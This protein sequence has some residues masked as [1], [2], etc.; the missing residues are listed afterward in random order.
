MG[1]ERDEPATFAE[2]L[3]DAEG[4][5]ASPSSLRRGPSIL[6]DESE[7]ALVKQLPDLLGRIQRLGL[8][9]EYSAFKHSYAAWRRGKS[10]GA[11]GEVTHDHIT[12]PENL[13]GN[14]RLSFKNPTLQ[15][16]VW[17]RTISYWICVTFFEGSLFFA[18]SCFLS[19]WEDE[20]G[21]VFVPLTTFGCVAGKACFFVGCYFMCLEVINM[22]V[23]DDDDSN[24]FYFWPYRYRVAL[25]KLASVGSDA[26][27]FI[28]G[29]TYLT[30]VLFYVVGMS[31]DF[32]PLSPDVAGPIHLWT[33]MVGAI[34]F[35]IG[36]FAE[37]IQNR[38][39]TRE[40]TQSSIAALL[41]FI[42][43]LLFSLG[44]FHGLYGDKWTENVSYGWGAICFAVAASI[45]IKM[46]KD[47]QFG[48]TFLTGINAHQ[49]PGGV[50]VQV[51]G[52]SE[53][54]RR[55]STFSTMGVIFVHIFSWCGAMSTY[56]VL[57]ELARYLEKGT[58]RD[59][60]YAFN[61]MMPCLFVHIMLAVYSAVLRTPKL[62]PFRQLFTLSRVLGVI[63]AINSSITF[64]LFVS[65]QISQ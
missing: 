63:L 12:R 17:R 26:S 41:N 47:E 14:R 58:F 31:C 8:L 25:D 53:N 33:F 42:G 49:H 22:E 21:P 1:Q 56:N 48:L 43:G 18:I 3:L 29:S 19:N 54:D 62:S 64:W 50:N 61:E 6:V 55:R 9:E 4:G 20:L 36:G 45:T 60:Q 44:S 2:P 39:F 40:W 38:I 23:G 13:A 57:V 59:F 46:W 34:W 51:G 27:P 11:K 10:K 35:A 7:A 37:C 65:R 24:T 32:L 5:N 16:W 28:C 30:G 52:D 15:E